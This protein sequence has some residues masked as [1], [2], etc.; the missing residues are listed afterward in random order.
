MNNNKE[1]LVFKIN[2]KYMNKFIN[3]WVKFPII[4]NYYTSSII[5][6]ASWMKNKDKIIINKIK[7]NEYIIKS[8]GRDGKYLR[9]K[10]VWSLLNDYYR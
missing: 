6:E 10:F 8:G 1:D 5:I 7:K 2:T 3:K 9:N 4:A